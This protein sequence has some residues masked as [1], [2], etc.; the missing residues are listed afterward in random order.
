MA[1]AT[2]SPQG[3]KPNVK[4]SPAIEECQADLS[5]S[6]HPVSLGMPVSHI[7][8]KEECDGIERQDYSFSPVTFFLPPLL[9]NDQCNEKREALS[10]ES[11]D[12]GRAYHREDLTHSHPSQE[13]KNREGPSPR[14]GEVVTV[15]CILMT[16]KSRRQSYNM[17]NLRRQTS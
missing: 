5:Q 8:L 10:V 11:Q 1:G 2:A 6:G 4:L 9:E 17:P 14:P 12:K 13:K 16:A 15:T 3:N 7:T